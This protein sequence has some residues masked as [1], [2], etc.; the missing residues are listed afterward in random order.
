MPET[1]ARKCDISA[2]IFRTYGHRRKNDHLFN[3][4][5]SQVEPDQA[6]GDLYQG[7]DRYAIGGLPMPLPD[8]PLITQMGD[9][10]VKIEEQKRRL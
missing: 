5:C 10:K 7:F 6:L 4:F 8:K 9:N 2:T 1:R 3:F